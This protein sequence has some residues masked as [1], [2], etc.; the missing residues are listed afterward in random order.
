MSTYSSYL[1][2]L[3]SIVMK[4]D[5]EYD[6]LLI[7]LDSISFIYIIERDQ[8]RIQDGID[9]R[10]SYEQEH[11]QIIDIQND[12]IHTEQ[13][14]SVLEVMVAIAKRCEDT[15]MYDNSYGDR[16]YIWFH[17]MLDSMEL[18]WM[19]DDNFNKQYALSKVNI[20]TNRLY[21]YYGHGGL[22]TVM[23][24]TKD[25]RTI[26]IWDQMHEYLNEQYLHEYI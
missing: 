20:M 10:K 16:T 5:E 1:S 3:K 26:E 13:S 2:W 12:G 19:T 15:I 11:G 24:P 14:C 6:K 22:F 23:F 17:E 8:N 7:L 21:D 9:L 25:M 4:E 18:L